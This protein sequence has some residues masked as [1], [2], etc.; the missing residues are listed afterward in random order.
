MGR[1]GKERQES[2]MTLQNFLKQLC[3]W[4]SHFIILG[5]NGE[6]VDFWGK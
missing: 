1:R 5:G 4:W 3:D 2:R 6:I